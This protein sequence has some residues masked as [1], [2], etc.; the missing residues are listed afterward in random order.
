[1]VGIQAKEL[2][3]RIAAGMCTASAYLLGRFHRWAMHKYP[4]PILKKEKG[5]VII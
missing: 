3:A 4:H 1:M 2:L 5:E